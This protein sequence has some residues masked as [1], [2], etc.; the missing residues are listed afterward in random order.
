MTRWSPSNFSGPGWYTWRVRV[1]AFLLPA[2]INSGRHYLASAEEI[3]HRDPQ[4]EYVYFE[5]GEHA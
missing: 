2:H 5:T 3:P 1:P 4:V